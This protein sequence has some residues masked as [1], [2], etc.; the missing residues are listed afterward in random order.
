MELTSTPG[1]DLMADNITRQE[2]REKII[3][4]EKQQDSTELSG[5]LF[6]NIPFS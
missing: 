5:F 4:L 3:W 6:Y 2:C 1:E